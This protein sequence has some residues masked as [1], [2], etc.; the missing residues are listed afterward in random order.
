MFPYTLPSTVVGEIAIRH[1]I[2]GPNICVVAGPDSGMLALWEGVGMIESGEAKGCICVGCDAVSRASAPFIAELPLGGKLLRCSAHAFLV[3]DEDVARANSR[4]P[5]AGVRIERSAADA[6]ERLG[7]VA[8]GKLCEFLM[9]MS[10]PSEATL[11]L[12]APAALRL[13]DALALVVDRR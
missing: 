12:A 3:E 1:R 6:A 9:P 2:T 7:A 13:H 5:L 8:L 4:V 11:R 10:S